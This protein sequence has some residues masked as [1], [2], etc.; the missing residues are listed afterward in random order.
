MANR[1][2][3]EDLSEEG[4]NAL[5][6]PEAFREAAHRLA[7]GRMHRLSGAHVIERR[8]EPHDG[9]WVEF[10]VWVTRDEAVRYGALDEDP[11]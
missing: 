11:R 3:F 10:E 6:T 8:A 4:K 5:A 9:A 1:L 2:R 7:R